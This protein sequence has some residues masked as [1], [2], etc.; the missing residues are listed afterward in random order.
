MLAPACHDSYLSRTAPVIAISPES[1][2]ELYHDWRKAL[3]FCQ[4]L[5]DVS[6][7]EPVTFHMYWRQRRAGF[8]RKVRPF[9]RK[10][11]LV[12]KAFLASQDLSRCSLVLWSDEDLSNAA[13]LRQFAGNLTFR[14]Y[15]PADEVRGTPLADRPE[16]YRQEDRRVW[17]DGDLFRILALHNY[18]GVYVDMDMV[19][20][21]SLGALLG[22]EFIYQWEDCDGVYNGAL[23]HLWKGSD[24]ARELIAGVMAIPPGEFNWG[25]D[26]LRRAVDLGRGVTVFPSP[27]F[28]TEWQADPKFKPFVNTPNS[29]NFY[30]GAFAWHWH[31]RWDAPIQNGSKFQRLE[32]RV[33]QRL[34]EMGI[35]TAPA[36]DG[37]RVD[38]IAI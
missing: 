15:R 38:D 13:S 19:L 12:V 21:R 24:F 29:A 28:D 8:W 23:M 4:T 32:A 35:L 20:L 18:G 11:A 26:N 9:G 36:A 6:P 3:A 22:Q 25:K 5:P 33:E 14:I 27:F 37:S 7:P 34:L 16:L 1:H 10:Q 31:N 2:Y 17:R 30:D